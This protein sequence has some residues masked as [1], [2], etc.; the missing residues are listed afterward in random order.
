M[1]PRIQIRR[2]KVQKRTAA[3]SVMRAAA[4]A[5]A[6]IASNV[7]AVAFDEFAQ[8]EATAGLSME[9]LVDGM[10]AQA[11]NGMIRIPLKK[12]RT[13]FLSQIYAEADP[14]AWNSDPKDVIQMQA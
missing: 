2:A 5:G 6:L 13:D 11:D 14:V 9:D 3:P 1:K 4:C 7:E 10:L 8:L 12:E